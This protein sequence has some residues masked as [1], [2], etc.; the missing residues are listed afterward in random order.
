MHFHSC[1]AIHGPFSAISNTKEG[2]E[3]EK[4]QA[5]K[6]CRWL[7]DNKDVE[8]APSSEESTFN[9]PDMHLLSTNPPAPGGVAGPRCRRAHPAWNT[10]RR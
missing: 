8:C 5:R 3:D 9:N 1:L 2:E 7:L 4:K 6:M 10:Y